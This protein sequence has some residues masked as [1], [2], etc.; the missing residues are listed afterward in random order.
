MYN[1]K[2]KEAL[3]RIK[4]EINKGKRNGKIIIFGDSGVGKTSIIRKLEKKCVEDTY[5]SHIESMISTIINSRH[6]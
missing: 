6:Y 5:L 3:K 4:G 2:G 1:L